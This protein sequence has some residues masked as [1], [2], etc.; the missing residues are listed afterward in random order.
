M[1]RPSSPTLLQRVRARIVKSKRQIFLPADF[2]DLSGRVQ[3]YRALKQLVDAGELVRVGS[4]LYARAR[5]SSLTGEP[6]PAVPGGFK[7]LARAA[8]D[9]LGV[10]WEPGSR[11]LAFSEGRT[12]QIPVNAVVRLRDRCRRRIAWGGMELR[13]E[14]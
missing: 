6:V 10:R 14:H 11:E 13:V 2:A 5:L 3:V 7:Y 1:F 8:L 9:R 12:N 4:G